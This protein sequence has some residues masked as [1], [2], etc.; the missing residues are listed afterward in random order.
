M[1]R[2]LTKARWLIDMTKH[3]KISQIP[4]IENSRADALAK[5]AS[6]D[7]SNGES[8]A[9]AEVSDPKHSHGKLAPRWEGPYRI[10]RV[11]RYAT[12]TLATLDGE[13]LPQT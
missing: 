10:T 3:F 4:H 6:T 5:S 2:Y 1:A 9:K 8:S 11:I 12:Y 7:I 13:V